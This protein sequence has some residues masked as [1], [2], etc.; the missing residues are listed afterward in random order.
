MT[1]LLLLSKDHTLGTTKVGKR[2]EGE[3]VQVVGIVEAKA[4]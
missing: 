1:L 3:S 2:L 4:I